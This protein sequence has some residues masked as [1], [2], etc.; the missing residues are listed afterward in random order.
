MKSLRKTECV[1]QNKR[2]T[3][4]CFMNRIVLDDSG[5]D[6][7][8]INTPHTPSSIG[9]RNLPDLFECSIWEVE[10]CEFG[11]TDKCVLLDTL[12]AVGY[13]YTRKI[14]TTRKRTIPD[15]RHRIWYCYTRK[16]TTI[17]ERTAPYTFYTT[18]DFVCRR[19]STFY[20][21]QNFTKYDKAIWLV[22]VEWGIVKCI[23]PNTRNA[24]WYRN[25]LKTAATSER[26]IPYAC[27]TFPITTPV[28]FLLHVT[29]SVLNPWSIIH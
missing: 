6:Y 10:G 14:S 9:N 27:H 3:F 1:S 19:T 24:V 25:T 17:I 8:F 5:F 20:L 4:V 28:T 13:C 23:I 11:T 7:G 18:R 26:T 12:Y 15:V 21:I 29:T 22:V 2:D 16:I